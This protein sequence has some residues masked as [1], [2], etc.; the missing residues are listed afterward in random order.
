[1][2]S[3]AEEASAFVRRREQRAVDAQGR[4]ALQLMAGIDLDGAR[5]GAAADRVKLRRRLLR[6]LERE[7]LLGLAR[8]WSYD[9]NRHIALKQALEALF[10]DRVRRTP[11]KKCGGTGRRRPDRTC[12]DH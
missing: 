7:R 3:L 8:H 10:P 2:K 5:A 6:L 4:V 11:P 9:L 12:P 1:M